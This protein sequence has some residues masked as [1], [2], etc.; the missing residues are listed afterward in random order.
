MGAYDD[1]VAALPHLTPDERQRISQRLGALGGMAPGPTT[2]LGRGSGP[3]TAH[4]PGELLLQAIVSTAE[5]LSGERASVTALRRTSGGRAFYEKAAAVEAFAARHTS[6][7]TQRLALL[8]LGVDLLY[9]DL[10]KIGLPTSTRSL[11]RHVHRI[12]S[13]IDASFPDYAKLGL[14]RMVMQR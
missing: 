5:R 1:V 13:V 11:M 9:R 10:T 3:E 8:E 6:T 2:P 4:Q 12:P 14:L 7:R